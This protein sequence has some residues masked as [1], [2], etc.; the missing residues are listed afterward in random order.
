MGALFA[1][2]L[3]FSIMQAHQPPTTYHKSHH[4][5]PLLLAL[6]L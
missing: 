2:T 1:L 4:Y 5:P 3:M 6:T